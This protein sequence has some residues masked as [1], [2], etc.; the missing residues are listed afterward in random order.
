MFS[1]QVLSLDQH[2]QHAISILPPTHRLSPE[3]S[4]KEAFGRQD[5]AKLCYQNWVFT[6]GFAIVVEKND[7]KG[8]VY[9]LECSRHKKENAA[10]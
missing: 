2:I 9:V 5:E 4:S 10:R 1:L 6:Q 8:G 3:V 7:I